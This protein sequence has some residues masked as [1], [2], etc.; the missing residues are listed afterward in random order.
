MREIRDANY[1]HAKRVW[2]DF[3][4]NNLGTYSDLYGLRYT[5]LLVDVLQNFWDHCKETN[6]LDPCHSFSETKLAWQACL[7]KKKVELQTLRDDVTN[8][9]V[10]WMELIIDKWINETKLSNKPIEEFFQL[11]IM[12]L[13]FLFSMLI[14]N[15]ITR[16]ITQWIYIHNYNTQN[17]TLWT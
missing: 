6:E 12:L 14:H 15:T 17:H 3:K 2:K 13:V 4:I 16:F 10:E 7:K 5:I 9:R 1:N 8:G 11:N